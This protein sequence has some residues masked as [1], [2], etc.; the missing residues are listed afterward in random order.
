MKEKSLKFRIVD[1]LY[2]IFS[3]LPIFGAI[4]IRILTNPESEGIRI[5][6]ANIFFTVKMPLQDMPI[7]ESQ[8]NAWCVIVSLFFLC[9]YL[10][11]GISEKGGL[12]RQMI[13]EWIVEKTDSLVK[14]NMGDY[15]KSFSPF[16]AA[17]L[18]L[19]ALSSLIT[20]VG[21][22]PPTSDL[23]VVAGWAVLVFI[24]I[25]YYKL[26]GGVLGYLKSFTEPIAAFTPFNIISEF[27]TPV[28]MS[29]RHYGNILSGSVISALVAAG[30]TGVSSAVLGWLPGAIGEFPLFRIG[31]PAVLSLY[32]DIFSGGLQAFIFAMLTMLNI[33]S[34]FPMEDWLA[35]IE[36]KRAKK[37]NQKQ[38]NEKSA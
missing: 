20:L 37:E 18:A 27:A 36:K 2:I 19:S 35:R 14:D 9:L 22:Y 25:T 6:G 21:L 31:I 28:S 7:T 5:T 4:V 24:L 10:T 26:K 30:L 1:A 13:A 16:I 38:L 34:A 33:S 23:N 17:M 29:F 15:F 32:F 3:V 12:R 8:V 11:H